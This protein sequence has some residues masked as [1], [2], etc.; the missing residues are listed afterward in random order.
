VKPDNEQALAHWG[1]LHDGKRE[2][3]KL[4]YAKNRKFY[5]IKVTDFIKII[6]SFIFFLRS[7]DFI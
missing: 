5:Q 4:K 2:R 1:L 6:S 3:K 7:A